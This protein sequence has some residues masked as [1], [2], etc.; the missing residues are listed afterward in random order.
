MR[1][2]DGVLGRHLANIVALLFPSRC[3]GCGVRGA[4]LC[5]GCCAGLPWLGD[6]ACPGCAMPVA[7]GARCHRC[8]RSPL[9]LDG[10]RAA[11]RF[12]DAARG[13]VHDLK[14]RGMR[15]RAELLGN[16]LSDAVM[17]RPLAIDLLLPVPLAAGRQRA[18]GFNQSALIAEVLGRRLAVPVAAGLLV[19]QRETAQQVGMS[20]AERRANMMGAFGCA[21]EANVRGVRVA[22]V[23]DVMTTGST[24][25]ACADVLR[26]AGAAR[27]YGIVVA[28]ALEPAESDLVGRN[29]W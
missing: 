9:P 15:D 20:A 27:V 22:V 26:A 18:R 5:L 28:R 23:D 10:V 21:D 3:V 1:A 8:L 13:V 6:R 17:R 25:A 24:L 7:S 2:G 4:A 14:Y 29:A 19:R 16:L 12:E 11:F